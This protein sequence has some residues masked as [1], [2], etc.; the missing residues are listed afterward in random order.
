MYLYQFIATKRESIFMPDN[1]SKRGL[2]LKLLD[3][4]YA[5]SLRKTKDKEGNDVGFD[6]TDLTNIGREGKQTHGQ[7]SIESNLIA[8]ES[9][10]FIRLLMEQNKVKRYGLNLTE[11]IWQRGRNPENENLIFGI[12]NG[13]ET[14]FFS[15][16]KSVID[17]DLKAQE[18]IYKDFKIFDKKIME[19]ERYESLRFRVPATLIIAGEHSVIWGSDAV[20]M[21]IPLFMYF[22]AYYK[23]SESGGQGII[24]SRFVKSGLELPEIKG[25]GVFSS[26]KGVFSDST[27]FHEFGWNT[28]TDSFTYDGDS[29]Q[30]P[31]GFKKP[32]KKWAS[33]LDKLT[34]LKFDWRVEI[35]S[36]IPTRCG[37]GSSGAL[38]TGLSLILTAMRNGQEKVTQL[39]ELF[40]E[41][42]IENKED[43]EKELKNHHL[44]KTF[45]EVINCALEIE[46]ESHIATSGLAPFV[47]LIGTSSYPLIYRRNKPKEPPRNLRV[48][49]EDEEKKER[50][51]KDYEVQWYSLLEEDMKEKFNTYYGVVAFYSLYPRKQ[52]QEII[53]AV[54]KRD[55]LGENLKDWKES[56]GFLPTKVWENL[57][58]K[59]KE[60]ETGDVVSAVNAFYNLERG[61]IKILDF[62][63]ENVEAERDKLIELSELI[64]WGQSVNGMKFTG[65]G[66]GGDLMMIS[67]KES[68]VRKLIPNHFP[69]HYVSFLGERE[70][71][72][73][74]L[75]SLPMSFRHLPQ[76]NGN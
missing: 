38:A 17:G 22:N 65:S 53:N 13:N 45:S 42:G 50:F 61:Y 25:E 40:D 36:E 34:D 30:I 23:K 63:R 33:K 28:T 71:G 60:P 1:K 49:E 72:Q 24:T 67:D 6:K 7:E 52:T 68:I 14:G 76:S 15:R 20:V 35:F 75:L 32:I 12:P 9:A 64:G 74:R 8:L 59:Q 19:E 57:N 66:N 37:L 55:V 62:R 58:S 2:A 70:D 46:S 18:W 41:G 43:M 27:N 69:I 3:E 47:S 4:A 73:D 51:F 16:L 11:I 44:V 31:D 5:L 48:Q 29:S 56:M 26:P 39:L 21:P 54:S 10:G